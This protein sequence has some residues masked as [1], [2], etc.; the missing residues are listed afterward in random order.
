M[1]TS[2]L[3]LAALTVLMLGGAMAPLTLAAQPA[4][5]QQ[6]QGQTPAPPKPYKQVAITLPQPNNDPTFVA[7]RKQ[8]GDAAAKKDRA[9]LAKLVAQ[10]IFLVDGEKDSADKKKSGI[11]NLA[12]A[13]NLDAKD[14]E[15]WMVIAEYAGEPT[16]EADP[17]HKGVIC[18]P[19]DPSFD[20]N[21]AEQLAQS[22]QTEPDEWG[23]PVKDGVEVRAAGKKDAPVTGKLGLFLVRVF[24]DNSPAAAVQGND[25]VR[26]VLPTGK[27]GYVASDQLL[28]LGNEQLCY[29]KDASGWKI[30]GYIGG[31]GGQQ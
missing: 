10:S 15:G 7:F 20:E 24:P 14:G 8:L 6:Q 27:F 21:A 3:T 18:A 4:Q 25:F 11:D 23:Y 9:G 19:A 26:V 29:S 5:G 2:H 31:S 13:L 17:D 22:T 28:P 12:K 16:T 30:A 1:R